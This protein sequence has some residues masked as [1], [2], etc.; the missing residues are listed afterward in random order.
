MKFFYPLLFLTGVSFQSFAQVTFSEASEAYYTIVGAF[1]IKNNASRFNSSLQKK[2]M[3]SD[4]G[5]LSSRN[6]YYVYT[7]KNSDVSVCLEAMHELR[8]KPEFWD[9]WVRFIG[10]G[11]DEHEARIEEEPITKVQEPPTT[12]AQAKPEEK[13]TAQYF[14]TEEEKITQPDKITLG[15]TEIFLSLYYTNNDKVAKGNVQVIDSD[16]GRLI[17]EVQGNTYLI[18]PDPKNKSGNL[19]LLCDV[20]GYR[21]IQKEINYNNPLADTSFIKQM[22]TSLIANFELVRYQRGDIKTLYNIY[23]YNDA[24]IMMPESKFELNALLEMLKENPDYNIKLHGHTNGNYRGKI[25]RMGP[26]GDFFSVSKDATTSLGS[27]RQLSESRAGVIRDYLVANGIDPSRMEVKA[28]GGKRPLYDK[29]GANA[30][31]NIRVE[32]EIVKD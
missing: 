8:K 12:I 20:M 28:W 27:A 4:W 32:V 18:L 2:G 5:Y 13:D 11:N 22:G 9:A 24:A 26:S 21:K 15:N 6:I 29:N 14:E 7:V 25:I 31:K 1:A 17:Q 3:R 16:R 19:T 23:F 30:K 10:S